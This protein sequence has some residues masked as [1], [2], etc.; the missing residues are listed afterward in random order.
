MG[1]NASK[2]DFFW[3]VLE[4]LKASPTSAFLVMATVVTG[5]FTT[6]LSLYHLRLAVLALTTHEDL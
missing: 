4:T 3:A 1:E 6:L 5:L 2:H